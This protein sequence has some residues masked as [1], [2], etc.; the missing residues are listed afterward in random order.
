M[1]TTDVL[2]YPRRRSSVQLKPINFRLPGEVEGPSDIE[3]SYNNHQSKRFSIFD[4]PQSTSE[5]KTPTVL[6]PLRLLPRD[7]FN[8][9]PTRSKSIECLF[10]L[11]SHSQ[12]RIDR[13]N[14]GES[15]RPSIQNERPHEARRRPRLASDQSENTAQYIERLR[16]ELIVQIRQPHEYN[17][18]F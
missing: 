17:Y 5:P 1:G 3:K 12:N 2:P 10:R 15:R 6:S 16:Q 14:P 8:N 4:N 7:I 11:R 18:V 9:E 13:T